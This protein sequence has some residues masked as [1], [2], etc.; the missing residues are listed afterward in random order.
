M[1]YL[2]KAYGQTIGLN[3]FNFSL[4]GIVEADG[5]CEL[6]DRAWAVARRRAE[7]WLGLS[8]VFGLHITEC[9]AEPEIEYHEPFFG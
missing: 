3:P 8:N 9:K 2:F 6:L 7:R 5:M 1:K 4:A